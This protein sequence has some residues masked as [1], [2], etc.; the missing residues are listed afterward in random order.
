MS[1]D[2]S[3]LCCPHCGEIYDA[4]DVFA[5]QK[6]VNDDVCPACLQ[7]VEDDEWIAD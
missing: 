7:A 3:K 5:F 1:D 2:S 6:E 4:Q